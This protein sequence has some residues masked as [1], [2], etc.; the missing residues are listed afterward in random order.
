[1]K[2]PARLAALVRLFAVL[3]AWGASLPADRP[4]N[5]QGGLDPAAAVR[6]ILE[7]GDAVIAGY[8]PPHGIATGNAFS[9]LYFDV[10]EGSGM[11][12]MIARRD[13]GLKVTLEA[14][15][16]AVISAAMRGASTEEVASHWNALK[17]RLASVPNSLRP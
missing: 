3:L 14:L 13:E 4:L 8:A 6:L 7:K 11:E 5:A 2:A 15:F 10:F 1:M 12:M 9:D 16:S 17:S